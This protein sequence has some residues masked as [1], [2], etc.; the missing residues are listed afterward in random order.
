M[1]GTGGTYCNE[2]PGRNSATDI[3]IVS[4]IYVVP[5]AS[6]P[7]LLDHTPVTPPLGMPLQTPGLK[8]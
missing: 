5:I 7:P 2:I 8:C 1:S 4:L 6:N 3:V